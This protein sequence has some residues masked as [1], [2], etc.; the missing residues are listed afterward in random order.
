MFACQLDQSGPDGFRRHTDLGCSV[1]IL[2]QCARNLYCNRHFISPWRR[3]SSALP[4]VL[5]AAE[6]ELR[7]P[8]RFV[9][10]GD[11]A[12][13]SRS[14]CR[15]R[16]RSSALPVVLSAAETELRPPGRFVGGGDGAPPSQ[17]FCRRRRRSSALPVVL[18]AAET[19]LR[20]PGRF[21]GGGDGAPPSRSFHVQ[22]SQYSGYSS[23]GPRLKATKLRLKI[24]RTVIA[25]QLLTSPDVAQGRVTS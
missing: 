1:T 10:G 5:S 18:S 2:S 14:F 11:G 8:S 9:G 6:T 16:R 24:K 4:I 15:R 12:P 7:P 23:Y 22:L 13:P 3:R 17:S 25:S 20:P 19:E 21:V